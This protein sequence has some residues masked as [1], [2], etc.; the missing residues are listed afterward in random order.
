MSFLTR[1]TIITRAPLALA[2]TAIHCGSDDSSQE[3]GLDQRPL[4]TAGE[5]GYHSYRIPALLTTQSGALLAFC[6]GRRNNRRDHGDIDLIMKRSTDGGETWSSHV[7][8]YEEGGSAD[9]TIGNP[10]PVVDQDTGTI[11]MPFCRDNKEVLITKSEDDGV[12]WSVPVNISQ[13][14]MH[15]HWV[16]VATGPG[17]S[18]QMEQ[19]PHKG[20]LVVPCDHGV[21]SGE[22]RIHHSHVFYSDDHGE[23]WQLGGLLPEH[24]DEAQVVELT[25]GRLLINMRSYWGKVAK[26]K[27]KLGKRA[28]A[29]SDDGGATWSDLAFDET[30]IEPVCQGSFVR[31]TLAADSGKDCVLFS[32]PASTESRVNMTVRISYDEGESWP[33]AKSLHSGPSA[34]SSLAALG[35]NTVACLYERGDDSAYETLTLARFTLDWLTDAEDRVGS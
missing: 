18:I 6:E 12:T 26:D 7:V 28:L 33:V 34:Y 2:A 20:R 23:T 14:V 17:V 8:V 22:Q 10:C 32:N 35:N 21:M 1:R 9:V 15:G 30:L 31:Y 5:D 16:W 11:W 19:G 27:G 29:W 25:D 3:A 24:T 4:W 13:G